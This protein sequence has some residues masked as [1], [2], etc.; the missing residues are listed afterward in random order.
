MSTEEWEPPAIGLVTTEDTGR[1]WIHCRGKGQR[2]CVDVCCVCDSRDGCYSAAG[3]CGGEWMNPA[4]RLKG[5]A[6]SRARMC[7]RRE[8]SLKRAG[9]RGG[10]VGSDQPVLFLDVDGVLNWSEYLRE[11]C[12]ERLNVTDP[13]VQ[14]LFGLPGDVV[15]EDAVLSVLMKVDRNSVV[16]LNRIT[17]DT[18]CAI[19]LS[20]TWRIEWSPMAMA[21]LLSL[22]GF[23]YPL[24]FV[25]RTQDEPGQC[26][27]D[28]IAAWLDAHGIDK[29]P[30]CILDD[31]W[32]M[33]SVAER[34]V[35]TDARFGLTEEKAD[36]AI[37]MLRRPWSAPG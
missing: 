3:S 22:R 36:E 32:R 34:L 23:R 7:V 33:G 37:E 8:G 1:T 25:G 12:A 6:T 31:G 2:V 21:I 9:Y 17:A 11:V 10:R 26:R 27:G 28:E 20:S 5:L 16:H 18:G 13:R 35:R 24:A 14:M 4:S 30:V 19:V 15:Y 29:Q